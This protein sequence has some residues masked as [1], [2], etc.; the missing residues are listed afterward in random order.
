M[1]RIARSLAVIVGLTLSLAATPASAQTATAKP[2]P[3]PLRL[4]VAPIGGNVQASLSAPLK[5]ALRAR[6]EEGLAATKVFTIETRL[7]R[8]AELV[9]REAAFTRAAAAKKVD[10]IIFP[11]VDSLTYAREARPITRMEGKYNVKLKAESVL[12]VRV[13]SARTGTLRTSF[14]LDRQIETQVGVIDEG[15]LP[16]SNF[17]PSGGRIPQ[18][19]SAADRDF[20]TLA[21]GLSKDLAARLYDDA[22][23]PEVIALAEG[24]VFVSRGSRGG[25]A[26]GDILQVY[27]KTGEVLRH[28]VT[29]EVLDPITIK[30][31]ALRVVEVRDDYAITEATDAA[32][33]FAIGDVVRR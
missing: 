23:P 12:R 14:E 3:E 27:R 9:L 28:P 13:V 26:V 16:A 31:G 21:Q 33:I 4:Y 32:A 29:G 17:S 11:E 5:E 15:Q 22:Y 8:E 30:A 18:T 25:L 6:I 24:R 2:P 19:M 10:L 20:V 7:D 1:T